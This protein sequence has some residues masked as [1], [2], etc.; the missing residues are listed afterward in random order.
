MCGESVGLVAA[1]CGG[2]AMRPGL[3]TGRLPLRPIPLDALIGDYRYEDIVWQGNKAR[4]D[5]EGRP[6]A[7]GERV[8]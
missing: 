1:A 7:R 8:G 2:A 5:D 3:W 6:L 4:I